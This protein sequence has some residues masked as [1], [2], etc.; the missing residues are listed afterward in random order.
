MQRA[1][2]YLLGETAVVLELEPP[3]TLESQKRIWGLTQRLTDRDG[4]TY[5][6]LSGKGDTGLPPIALAGLGLLIGAIGM[7]ISAAVAL[8]VVLAEVNAQ[9]R[10]IISK[11]GLAWSFDVLFGPGLLDNRQK[12]G[13]ST[14]ATDS[15]MTAESAA[16]SV[17]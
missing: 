7:V 8:L 3:V 14:L 4:H 15:S 11:D 5:F 2:C 6:L 16:H 13:W 10:R 17:R 12:L 9:S 1:R